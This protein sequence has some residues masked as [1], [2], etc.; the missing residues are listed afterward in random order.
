MSRFLVLNVTI[1][2]TRLDAGLC[3]HIQSSKVIKVIKN[4]TNDIVSTMTSSLSHLMT[5][6]DMIS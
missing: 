5:T 3:G 1:D 4:M 2:V 6:H